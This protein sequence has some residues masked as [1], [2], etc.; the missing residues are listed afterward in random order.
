[1]TTSPLNPSALSFLFAVAYFVS[2]LTRVNYSAVISEMELATGMSKSMLSMALTGSFFTYGAGQVVSGIMGDRISPKKLLL[3]GLLLSSVMNILLPLC[4]NAYQM[5]A[6]WCVNGF[7]QAFMWPPLVK[8]MTVCLPEEQY[9]R[10]VVRAS[11]GCSLGTVA[12]YLLSPAIISAFCWR[13]VFF[14]SAVCGLSMVVVWW[15][16]CPETAPVIKADTPKAEAAGRKLLFCP[17]MLGIMVAITLH[18]MLK[19]GVSTWM[20]SYI[21]ET[22]H[23]GNLIAILTGVVMPVFSVLSVEVASRVYRRFFKNPVACAASVFAVSIGCSLL[24]AL[25]SNA[26]P[27]LSVVL[28]A[29]LTGSMHGVNLML[30]STIPPFFKKYNAVSTASGVLNA[31]TY[32]GSAVS[33]Y[34]I[35]VV[36]ENYSWQVTLW[37]WLGIAVTAGVLCLLCMGPF[38]KRWF[39]SPPGKMQ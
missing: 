36:S 34:G 37:L 1:M 17:T 10:S 13:G 5:L 35:A 8:L 22:Y 24:L 4:S 27:A 9:Q 14:A 6:V 7:A 21:S 2:Y 19:D 32:I 38:R 20:P 3:G 29:L 15:L 28:S 25:F 33:A 16:L 31:C 12:V 23:V 18:G 30:I 11:Y 26:N 39:D